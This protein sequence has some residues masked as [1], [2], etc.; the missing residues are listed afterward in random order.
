MT[1]Q[2]QYRSGFPRGYP[3]LPPHHHCHDHSDDNDNDVDLLVMR[4]DLTQPHSPRS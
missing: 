1:S 3:C 4:H 2:V